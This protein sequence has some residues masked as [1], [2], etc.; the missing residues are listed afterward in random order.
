[1]VIWLEDQRGNRHGIETLCRLTPVS[2]SPYRLC[3]GGTTAPKITGISHLAVYTSD[4]AATEHYYVGILGAAKLADPENAN[5]VIYAFS[6]TQYI[7]VLPLPANSGVNRLDHI[8]FNTTSAEGMRKYLAAKDWKVPA[9]INHGTD[10][11]PL[12]RGARYRGQ[13]G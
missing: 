13:Q 7:E 11:Q 1:M 2:R 3:A 6:A 10:E 12:V 5:G 8:A 4:A 9:H